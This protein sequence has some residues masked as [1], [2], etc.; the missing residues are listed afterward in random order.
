VSLDAGGGGE[1][2]LECLTPRRD[3][4]SSMTKGG[5]PAARRRSRSRGPPARPPTAGFKVRL[6]SGLGR[7]SPYPRPQTRCPGRVSL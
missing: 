5:A 1:G 6:R 2:Y 3:C 7:S 4:T